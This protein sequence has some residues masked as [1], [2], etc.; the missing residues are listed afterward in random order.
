LVKP[1]TL[2]D[3]VKVREVMSSPVVEADESAKI[4]EVAELMR[5]H[6]I[7]SIIIT[8]GGKPVGIITKTDIVYQV[9][10]N[11]ADAKNVR[12]RN[13]MS[14]PLQTVEPDVNIEDALSKM[15]RLKVGRLAVVYKERLAGIVT[16]KDILTVTPEILAIVK[17]R[18]RIGIPT[19]SQLSAP[20]EGYCESCGEWSD[21]LVRVDDQLLCEDC[22]LE[23]EKKG[24][25]RP[26]E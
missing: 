7:G 19:Q 4:V 10:A 6:G 20:V 1:A 12:A 14:T 18:M 17:E 5:R 26:V 15:N 13:I 9:V 21:M 24:G 23:L 25:S 11:G 3:E 8:S 22:R 2:V 16:L